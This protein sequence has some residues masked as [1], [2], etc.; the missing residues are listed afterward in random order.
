LHYTL[1][2]LCSFKFIFKVGIEESIVNAPLINLQSKNT[3]IAE[4]AKYQDILAIA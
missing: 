4:S 3:N 2:V 1:G